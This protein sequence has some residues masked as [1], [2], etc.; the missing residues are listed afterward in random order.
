MRTTNVTN[1]LNN[2]FQNCTISNGLIKTSAELKNRDK[3]CCIVRTRDHLV[4]WLMGI[5][6]QKHAANC[7][8]QIYDAAKC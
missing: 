2:M 6:F 3:F 8:T 5:L 1:L 7:D 4:G